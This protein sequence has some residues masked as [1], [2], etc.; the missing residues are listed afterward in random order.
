M[1]ECGSMNQLPSFSNITIWGIVIFIIMLVVGI[2][3][4]N[5]VIYA[6]HFKDS[7]ISILILV[8]CG[9]GVAGLVFAIIAIVTN[10]LANM[11]IAALC[12][13]ISC[14]VNIVLLVF[15][16]LR[17]GL[18]IESILQIILNVFLCYLFFVQSNGSA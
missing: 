15:S 5:G 1:V 2:D 6:L 18:Y 11:K 4:V 3:S 16:I 7:L 12:F 10:N 14:L 17:S 8:G 9:F 13:L